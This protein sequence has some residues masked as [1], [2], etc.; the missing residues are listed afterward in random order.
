MTRIFSTYYAPQGFT[1]LFQFTVIFIYYC[2]IKGYDM[3]TS[4][5]IDE[6]LWMAD[7]ISS[8]LNNEAET[9]GPSRA[10]DVV[11]LAFASIVT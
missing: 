4:T 7:A 8:L 9:I 11:I 6:L 3:Q 5:T 1:F 10:G 2:L